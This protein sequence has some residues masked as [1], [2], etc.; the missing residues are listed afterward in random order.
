MTSHQPRG[1]SFSPYF[2]NEVM[3]LYGIFL[4]QFCKSVDCWLTTVS[5]VINCEQCNF[6]SENYLCSL[7]A[8]SAILHGIFNL[9][10]IQLP[11]L[12]LFPFFS[13]YQMSLRPWCTPRPGTARSCSSSP[14]CTA[15]QGCRRCSCCG[16]GPRRRGWNRWWRRTWSSRCPRLRGFQIK[17]KTYTT[18]FTSQE[19][20]IWSLELCVVDA[21]VCPKMNKILWGNIFPWHGFWRNV[22]TAEKRHMH[23]KRGRKERGPPL[24]ASAGKK[25]KYFCSKVVSSSFFLQPCVAIEW[26]GEGGGGR[27]RLSMG[28]RN[29]LG[30]WP[31]IPLEKEGRGGKGN[32]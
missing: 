23:Q 16:M 15:A 19:F 20:D 8:L 22:W 2:C 30:K 4:R 1:E 3:E 24:M 7:V 29:G 18:T 25:P 11:Q 6:Y 21:I 28:E 17:R 27:K 9:C 26:M 31:D 13:T 14:P 5:D 10:S 12:L 32:G